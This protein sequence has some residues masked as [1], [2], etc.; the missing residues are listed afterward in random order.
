MSIGKC[1][2][3]YNHIGIK[4]KLLWLFFFEKMILFYFFRR[5]YYM[6]YGINKQY[7]TKSP[8]ENNLNLVRH[9]HLQN[10]NAMNQ[11]S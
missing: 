4:Q 5:R 11:C 3:Q 10:E 7:N 8:T 6:L 1:S 9:L 2:I